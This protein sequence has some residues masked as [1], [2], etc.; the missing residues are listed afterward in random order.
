MIRRYVVEGHSMEPNF[1]EGDKLLV[2]SLFFDLKEGDVV[3]FSSC[4]K[5]CLKR[6]MAAEGK[7]KFVAAGDNR[8]HSRNYGIT[9]S[10]IKGKFLMKY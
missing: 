1:Y 10:Q 8:S 9:R 5:D 7:G 2:S 4:N 6:I 3:V